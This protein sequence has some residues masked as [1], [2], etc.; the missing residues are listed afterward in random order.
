VYATGS[1][2]RDEASKYS[3]LDLFIVGRSDGCTRALS[4]LE[5]ICVKADLIEATQALEIPDFSGDVEYLAGCGKR[6]EFFA[7]SDIVE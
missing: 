1:F 7:R 3:D 2:G 4:K 6:E 5:E